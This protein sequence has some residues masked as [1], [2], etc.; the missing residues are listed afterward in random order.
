MSYHIIKHAEIVFLKSTI[1]KLCTLSRSLWL[2]SAFPSSSL[3][4]NKLWDLICGPMC[5]MSLPFENCW[6]MSWWSNFSY[7]L[8]RGLFTSKDSKALVLDD[9]SLPV[10]F[11][12]KPPGPQHI[13]PKLVLVLYRNSSS[14]VCLIS[15]KYIS[16]MLVSWPETS[17][18]PPHWHFLWV[19]T[20][21][22]F[23]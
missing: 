13:Q 11:S 21:C 18:Q 20:T 15:G 3:L 19:H 22:H 1:F 17:H 6:A 9:V 23:I 7:L 5:T 16:A 12:W 4:S 10:I 14:P 2:L 8:N